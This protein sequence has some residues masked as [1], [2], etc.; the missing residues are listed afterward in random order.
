MTWEHAIIQK[1]VIN[2]DHGGSKHVMCAWDDCTNDG[3]ELYKVVVN[4][5]APGYPDQ[6]IRYV[7]CKESHKMMWVHSHRRYGHLP[8]G[9][10]CSTL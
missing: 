3:Y 2:L 4:D 5:A 9:Y 1:K 10:R 6:L 8:P 7:F